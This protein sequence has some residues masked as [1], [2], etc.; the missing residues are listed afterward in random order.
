MTHMSDPEQEQPS[1][2][3]AG[4]D[5]YCRDGGYLGMV[6]GADERRFLLPRPEARDERLEFDTELV[7]EEEPSEMRARI[8]L[9]RSEISDRHEHIGRIPR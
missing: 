3:Q 6:L 2:V 8:S 9:E 5:I 7:I 1:L 4:W